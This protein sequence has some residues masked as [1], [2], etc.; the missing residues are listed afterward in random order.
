M[1]G[2]D[3]K[4]E[5]AVCNLAL[6]H[7]GV[8]EEI[9]NLE[10]ERSAAA[11]ACRRYITTA[12]DMSLRDFRWPFATAFASLSLVE[13]DP[14]T[15]WKYSY[16]YP[17]D[18]LNFRRILSGSRNDSRETR[19]P[20]KLASDDSG[21]LIYT[22]QYQAVCEYTKM[23]S[24]PALWPD[25]F[26]LMMSYLL[27]SLISPRVTRGDGVKLGDRAFEI[28]LRSKQAAEVNA[29]NEEQLDEPPEAESIRARS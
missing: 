27:A 16:R 26:I 21:K 23:M 13:E 11:S 20:Y 9:Q 17:S 8:S 6:G 15:E 14:N 2:L 12:R 3:N 5:V 29:E 19:I 7:L 24:N 18:C 4:S 1:A 22:D 28:Y 25:D 10:T